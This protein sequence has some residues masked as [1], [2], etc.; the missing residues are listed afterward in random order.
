MKKMS[1]VKIDDYEQFINCK[2]SEDVIRF[3]I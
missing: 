2:C 1:K 3:R